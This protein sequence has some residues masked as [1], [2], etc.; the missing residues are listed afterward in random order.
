MPFFSI[1]KSSC[2]KT[3]AVKE[4]NEGEKD[5]PSYSEIR[6]GNKSRNG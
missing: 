4:V 6:E 3:S 2:E 1:S 5:V